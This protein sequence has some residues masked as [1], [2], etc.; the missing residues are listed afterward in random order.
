MNVFVFCTKLGILRQ[1]FCRSQTV[2]SSQPTFW[3]VLQHINCPFSKV[4]DFFKRPVFDRL[5]AY[6]QS[7]T[8]QTLIKTDGAATKAG[9][10]MYINCTPYIMD[11][12]WNNAKLLGENTIHKNLKPLV[13]FKI[14]LETLDQQLQQALIK[15]G[16]MRQP[17]AIRQSPEKM[18]ME[19]ERSPYKLRYQKNSI[20]L[21]LYKLRNCWSLKKTW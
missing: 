2:L 16:S 3:Q 14:Q 19:Q 10:N 5:Q 13:Q 21:F 9:C 12:R 4:T 20:L 11:F 1:I 7:A 18:S 8:F 6:T 15:C 17:V